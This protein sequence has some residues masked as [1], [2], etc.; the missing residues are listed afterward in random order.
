MKKVTG[1][2]ASNKIEEKF[3]FE[4]SSIGESFASQVSMGSIGNETPLRGDFSSQMY[5]NSNILRYNNLISLRLPYMESGGFLNIREVIRLCQT[6]YYNVP[7][8]NHTIEIMT[9]LTNTGIKLTGGTPKSRQF[10]KTWHQ[11]INLFNL[12]EQFF[13]ECYRSSNMFLYRYDGGIKLNKIN[14]FILGE[15]EATFWNKKHVSEAARTIDL[16]LRY[17]LL[18]PADICTYNDLSLNYM[19]S[20]YRIMDTSTRTQIKRLLKESTVKISQDEELKKILN[21]DLTQSLLDQTKLYPLFYK[22]QDYEPFAMPFGYP[23]LEDINLKLELKKC[24]AVVAKTVESIIM[25]VTHG[26]EPDKGGMNPK[27]DSALKQVFTTKQT[28]RTVVS[29]YT[30]KIDFVIP[31]LN[32]V[33]GPEKYSKIDQDIND[34]LMNLFFGE[35]KFA[36]ITEK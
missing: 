10:Y 12:C 32:K 14:K 3:D 20:Y 16:P 1:K 24:D 9:E 8:F 18:N 6:A 15:E 36:N 2:I 5:S 35:Q 7:V 13:R 34:G 26:A 28:G 30:T 21:L 19:P 29:D 27:V 4:P 17:V 31:D 23:V 11:K 22:K 25:L 33:L